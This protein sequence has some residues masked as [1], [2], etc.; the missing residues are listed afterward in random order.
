[1][2]LQTIP[3]QLQG[4]VVSDHESREDE[5]ADKLFFHLRSAFASASA[6]ASAL[7]GAD[8]ISSGC[9]R[10]RIRWRRIKG[11]ASAAMA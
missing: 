4:L 3:V 5:N 6:S 7:A 1:M 11:F 9:V 2:E 8:L 10:S